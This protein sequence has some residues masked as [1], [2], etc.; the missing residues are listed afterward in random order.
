MGKRIFLKLTNQESFVD[1][2]Y[3]KTENYQK[4]H[5]KEKEKRL[6]EAGSRIGR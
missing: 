2:H 1:V 4:I 6:R 5:L 3:L